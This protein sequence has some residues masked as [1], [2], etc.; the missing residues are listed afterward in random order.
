MGTEAHELLE[1]QVKQAK[2]ELANTIAEGAVLQQQL[3]GQRVQ[4][5]GQMALAILSIVTAGLAAW[6]SCRSDRRSTATYQLASG[7]VASMSSAQQ[8]QYRQVEQLRDYTVELAVSATAVSAG[9][10]ASGP[11]AGSSSGPVPYKPPVRRPP[12]P[13]HPPPDIALPPAP[14]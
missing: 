3:R 8:Q 2:A 12:P 1:L 6:S 13:T 4:L 11:G 5:R 10:V 7:A 14:P 9:P